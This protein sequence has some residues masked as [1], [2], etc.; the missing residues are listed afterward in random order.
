MAR[1]DEDF[2][3]FGY[4]PAEVLR[5]MKEDKERQRQAGA[6]ASSE[7]PP[8]GYDPQEV[9]RQMREE[10]AQH[11]Q[12]D[13]AQPVT[14]SESRR[15]RKK[16]ERLSKPEPR[17]KSGPKKKVNW[18]ARF[19][20]GFIALSVIAALLDKPDIIPGVGGDD[21]PAEKDRPPAALPA[22]L[23]SPPKS[24]CVKGR[25]TWCG[26][27]IRNATTITDV[28][29]KERVP[30]RAW[31]IGVMTAMQESSI[32]SLSNPVYPETKS[33][34]QGVGKDHDS[35]GIFQQRPKAGWGRPTELMN[36]KTA[37]EKFYNKLVKIKGW[38]SMPRWQAA[39]KVQ[40][41]CCPRAY[42]KHEAD[43][44]K[45][46]TFIL[47]YNK[48][49]IA[50]NA[51]NRATSGVVMFRCANPRSSSCRQVSWRLI[52]PVID[53]RLALGKHFPDE[54]YMGDV[55]DDDHQNA[56]VPQDH[57]P[58]ARGNKPGWIYAQDLG[59]GGGFDLPR[60]NRWLLDN[61]RKGKYREVKYVI[62]RL[63]QMRSVAGGRYYGLFRRAGG[64]R[65]EGATGHETHLHIS[66][67]PGYERA[68]STIIADYAA[69]VRAQRS[70]Q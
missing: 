34:G 3:P 31:E 40:V 67:M 66:Y 14:P 27:P 15:E 45:V 28:G 11:Q 62:C 35:V 42:Y 8:F 54:R 26:V 64:W 65:K 56:R 47:N 23:N 19:V 63:P 59:D 60:F 49:P 32:R 68:H 46:V 29:R 9:L 17:S 38:Q 25:R 70:Q 44:I 48:L 4:D 1:D 53:N 52:Q 37:S 6:S 50:R 24:A 5:Q 10:R 2:P 12:Y 69:W 18:R 20:L 55:G 13:Y 21:K 30:R 33:L 51:A 7:A 36:P 58:G 16:R 43:A 39:Q 61:L 41:S 57:T 22:T